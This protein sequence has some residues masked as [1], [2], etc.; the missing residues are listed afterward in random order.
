MRG[1]LALALVFG[2]T[3]RIHAAQAPEPGTLTTVAAVRALS[4]SA[5]AGGLPVDLVATVTFFRGYE[6]TLFIQQ[7]ETG[8]YVNAATSLRLEPGDVVRVV[9]KTAADF[10]PDIVSSDI[11]LLRQGRMPKPVA[12]SWTSLANAE[13]DSRW[14]SSRGTIMLAEKGVSSDHPM[15]HLVLELD[16]G[17]AEILIDG[18]DPAKLQGLPNAEVEVEGVAGQVFDGKM[19]QI[20]V[21]LHVPSL[22]EIHLL[23]RSAV[24]PWTMPLTP[25]DK[26][27]RGYNVRES[28]PRVRVEGT[29]I[30]YQQAEMAVIEDGAKTIRM[31]TS[32]WDP[33]NL[34]QRV[35]AVGI[36]FVEDR[37]LT[38][39]MG[40]IRA[41][42]AGAPVTPPLVT[43]DALASGKYSFNL[44]SIDA[45]MVSQMREQGQDI[46]VLSSGEHLFSASLRRLL[47]SPRPAGLSLPPMRVIPPGSKVRVTGVVAQ[48]TGNPFNGPIAFG[49]LL[50]SGDDIAM[51]AEPPWLSV[52]H[53]VEVS[54]LLL[55]AMVAVGVWAWL[56][57][58]G[59]RRKIAGMAYLERRRAAIL[60]MI[61]GGEPLA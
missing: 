19:Q 14:V 18:Y 59:T 7:G 23:K 12:A 42:G 34:G 37:Q 60:E 51:T 6:Q 26:V 33:V 25:I 35:D 9:G 46:Y 8:I 57:E 11:A 55:L 2:G 10:S 22:A 3:V 47:P 39:G 27:L 5:A 15:S 50:R 36:P 54:G 56:L 45:T 38:L 41:E 43:W 44:I 58:R 24:D 48:E 20:G 1:L 40:Q 52:R 53:M 13:F 28:T 61:N 32:Q 16:G 21:R 49:L 30:Y 29:L 31:L 17:K 4:H